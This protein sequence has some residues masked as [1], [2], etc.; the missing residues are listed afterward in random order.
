MTG[1]GEWG[2]LAL[3][4]LEIQSSLAVK[5]STFVTNNGNYGAEQVRNVQR[6]FSDHLCLLLL[7]TRF[8]VKL[9]AAKPE[10]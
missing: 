5:C 7:E 6:L 4:L 8:T 1:W 2:V 10:Q 3:G 9:K